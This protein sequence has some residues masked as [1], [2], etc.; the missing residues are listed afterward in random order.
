MLI[1]GIETSCDDSAAAIFDSER[2][3]L[4]SIISSQD[5]IHSQFGGI[6]P[7][8][9]SREH[10]TN[11][12]LVIESA[13]SEIK[14]SMSD[15]SAVAVTCGPGLIGSLLVG[16]C[17]AKSIS[18]ALNIPFIGINHL[19]G[20][21]LSPF[22]EDRE[23]EYPHLALVVS[24]GHTSLYFIEREFEYSLIASTRDDAAGEALDKVAKYLGLGFPGGKIID[25]RGKLGNPATIKFPRGMAKRE[26]FDFS[27]S[28]L[29]SSVVRYIEESGIP[30]GE[31]DLNN[32]LASFQEAV[33]DSLV[34][35]IEKVIKSHPTPLLTISG[36]VAAN[37]RLRSKLSNLAKRENFKLKITQM[38][39][40]TD[41][42]AMIAF[43]G[44]RHL[45]K[46]ES[47][48]LSLNAKAN[49]TL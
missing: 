26:S 34:D 39:Y 37:S 20:H 7:E 6:V 33:V 49:L 43:A 35:K 28:G 13:L 24:G 23:I 15:L 38:K 41:N 25:E 45:V 32:L 47:S 36:G 9:A 16:L 21:L 14:C 17:S 19:E 8:M 22:I 31:E 11:L 30:K 18:F 10:L 48:P 4:S 2:G 40:C 12:P 44:W 5:A 46:G 42:A 27:F 1:L 3:I 29:K